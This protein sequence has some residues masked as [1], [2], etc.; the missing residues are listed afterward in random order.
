MT[1]LC[2]IMISCLDIINKIN[3][4]VMWFKNKT[5]KTYTNALNT[6]KI[7]FVISWK[8]TKNLVIFIHVKVFHSKKIKPVTTDLSFCHLSQNFK[9][10]IIHYKVSCNLH[11]HIISYISKSYSP[12]YGQPPH[13]RQIIVFAKSFNLYLWFPIILLR[14]ETN[15]LLLYTINWLLWLIIKE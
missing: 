14:S 12:I 11:L 15:F 8:S 2:V 7:M 10:D 13:S 1:F 5:S 3:F 4:W 9:A 6:I